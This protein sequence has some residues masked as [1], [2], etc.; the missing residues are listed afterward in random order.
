MKRRVILPLLALSSMGIGLYIGKSRRQK[1]AEPTSPSLG[2][3]EFPDIDKTIRN[4]EEWLGKIV[5]VNHWATWCPPCLKEIPVFIEYQRQKGGQGVQVIGIAH[6][7]LD[8]TR[9]FSDEIGMNYPS[10]VAIIGGGELMRAQGN[11]TGAL[12]F[13]AIYDQSGQLARTHLG[14]MDWEDIDKAVSPL[15]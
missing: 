12:P 6:D 10:L 9:R 4:A 5:V 14:E 11:H 3:I 7:L 13:T 15:L 2:Q 8:A 1:P